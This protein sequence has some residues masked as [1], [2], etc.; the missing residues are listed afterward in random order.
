[1]LSFN[2]LLRATLD[3]NTAEINRRAWVARAAQHVEKEDDF[4][5]FLDSLAG[6]ETDDTPKP[7][8]DIHALMRDIGSI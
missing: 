6:E 3:V 1:M 4:A 2:A 8:K 7:G 5:D